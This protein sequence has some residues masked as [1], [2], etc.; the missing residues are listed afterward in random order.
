MKI[1]QTLTKENLGAVADALIEN[2]F[3]SVMVTEAGDGSSNTPIVFVNEAFTTLTGY[4]ADDVMGKSPSILQGADTDEAVINR[5]RE[6][7]GTGKAFEG[8][9]TNYRKDGTPFTMHW[10]VAPVLEEA[11]KP[12]YYIAVQRRQS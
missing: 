1:S 5:L 12:K 9:T 8:E 6:N 2:S 4:S 3:D 7:I 10:R 11:G